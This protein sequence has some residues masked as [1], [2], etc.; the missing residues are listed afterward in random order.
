MDRYSKKAIYTIEDRPKVSNFGLET[1][2]Q[3][4]DPIEGYTVELSLFTSKTLFK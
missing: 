4:V 2:P 1:I 3:F